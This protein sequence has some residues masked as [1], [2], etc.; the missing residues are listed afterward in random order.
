MSI[1]VWTRFI[2]AGMCVAVLA[3]L[4]SLPSSKIWGWD[5][6]VLIVS[7]L[8]SN[9]DQRDV[10]PIIWKLFVLVFFYLSKRRFYK[11]MYCFSPSKSAHT[12]QLLLRAHFCSSES[13]IQT[14]DVLGNMSISQII[15]REIYPCYLKVEFYDIISGNHLQSTP[16]SVCR[17]K[18]H[19]SELIFAS[20]KPYLASIMC[21]VSQ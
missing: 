4:I 10:C 14:Q 8:K 19:L 21:V 15:I 20:S 16:L 1:S 11:P 7:I 13:F 6:H 2:W 17:K 18:N 5:M 3:S 9:Q 12:S